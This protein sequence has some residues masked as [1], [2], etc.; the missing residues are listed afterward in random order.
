MKAGNYWSTSTDQN[1]ACY[2]DV[3][4]KPLQ[5]TVLMCLKEERIN[6]SIWNFLKF[7]HEILS[8]KKINTARY[9]NWF[10]SFQ[11][12]MNAKWGW[13]LWWTFACSDCN[14]ELSRHFCY[15][16]S[17]ACSL[18]CLFYLLQIFAEFGSIKNLRL[19]RDIISGF[20]K[21]SAFIE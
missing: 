8:L 19:V 5:V 12:I 10:I 14:Q 20:S 6:H 4:F 7:S 1:Q 16:R 9:H 13:N 21:R 15:I 18:L 2:K 17:Q 3:V 11:K